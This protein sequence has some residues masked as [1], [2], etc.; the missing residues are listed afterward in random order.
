MGRMVKTFFKGMFPFAF[1]FFISNLDTQTGAW[2]M[3]FSWWNLWLIVSY[4]VFFPLLYGQSWRHVDRSADKGKQIRR[5]R[6]NAEQE[7]LRIGSNYGNTGHFGFARIGEANGEENT[8]ERWG[9]SLVV[10][11]FLILAGPLVWI[12]L[13]LMRHRKLIK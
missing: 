2:R 1:I 13:W 6:Q 8:I 4:L 11:L 12:Y 5:A 9:M 7:S 10:R 3:A